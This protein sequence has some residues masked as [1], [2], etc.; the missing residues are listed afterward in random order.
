VCT[1]PLINCTF[2]PP[3]SLSLPTGWNDQSSNSGR[4]FSSSPKRPDWLWAPASHLF[5]GYLDSFPGVRQPGRDADHSPPP[6]AEVKSERSY[7]STLPSVASW[8]VR[9]NFAILPYSIYFTLNA[10]QYFCPL[11]IFNPS[12]KMAVKIQLD[13]PVFLT[14]TFN[15][16]MGQ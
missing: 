15:H 11:C 4:R 5:S 2:S 13:I 3:S 6:N 16:K 10:T 1:Y 8:R 7:T 9:D 12:S 14:L